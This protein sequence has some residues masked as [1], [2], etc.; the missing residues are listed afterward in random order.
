MPLAGTAGGQQAARGTQGQRHELEL[1]D[2]ELPQLAAT[3]ITATPA[4]ALITVLRRMISLLVYS[5]L[6]S[7]DLA[8]KRKWFVCRSEARR[9][10]M[11][12]TWRLFLIFQ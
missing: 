11:P 12:F 10:R 8:A 3:G 6:V 1:E 2:D 5:S 9:F 4:S 7:R